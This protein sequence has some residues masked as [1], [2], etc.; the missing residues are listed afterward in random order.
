MRVHLFSEGLHVCVFDAIISRS[1]LNTNVVYKQCRSDFSIELF[2][3]VKN[4]EPGLECL[5]LYLFFP[6]QVLK[7]W[8]R[9]QGFMNFLACSFGGE[10]VRG[11]LKESHINYKCPVD[12][13]S[14]SQ[15][16]W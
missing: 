1:L 6:V 3:H 11:N 10:G 8:F 12:E 7:T 4:I 2:P 14:K 16:I 9:F 13:L 15:S 5:M